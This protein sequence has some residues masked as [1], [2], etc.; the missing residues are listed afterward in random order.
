MDAFNRKNRRTRGGE[1][2]SDSDDGP[3]PDPDDPNPPTHV[4]KEPKPAGETREVTVSVRKAEDKGAQ[5]LTGGLTAARREMLHALRVEE[6]EPWEDFDYCDG[7]V[8][9]YPDYCI[10]IHLSHCKQTEEAQEAFDAVFSKS[11][12]KLVCKSEFSSFLK[13]IPGL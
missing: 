10:S 3:P 6:E 1:D 11:Q 5:T 7:E 13:N 8:R 2:D 12:D 4:K 9:S